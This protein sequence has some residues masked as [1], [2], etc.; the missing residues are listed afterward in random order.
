[1]KI[2]N[3]SAAD[4]ESRK[5]VVITDL[6]TLEARDAAAFLTDQGYDVCPVPEDLHLWDEQSLS[7]FAAPLADTLLGVIHPAPP[8][9]LSPLLETSEE[10]FAKARDEGPLSAWCVTKV[11]GNLFRSRGDGCLIYLSSIHA[12]KPVG[13]GFLF[14]TGCAAVQMLA[15][16][17]NQDYGISGV[18]SYFVQRGPT[19]SD[20]DGRTSLSTLYYG[21][22]LRYPARH[23]PPRGQ[24]NSLLAFLLSPESAPLSGSDLRADG[25]MTM[26]YGERVTAEQAEEIRLRRL[27]GEEGAILGEK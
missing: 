10:D 20:P 11:F 5:T 23:L 15:R 6:R 4:A 14:S 27:R 25:G 3:P 2:M 9:F 18:R 7:A 19:A 12:E 13:H 1:M 17:V 24:L 22:P 8:F 16:E 26:Y 21:L